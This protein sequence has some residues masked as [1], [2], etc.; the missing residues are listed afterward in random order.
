MS[1]QRPVGS[2]SSSSSSGSSK[3]AVSSGKSLT[4]RHHNV[5][6]GQYRCH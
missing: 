4:C 3:A 6:L 2:S 5:L 1:K